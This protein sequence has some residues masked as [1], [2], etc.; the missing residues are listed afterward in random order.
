MTQIVVT[1]ED[2]C[3]ISLIKEAISQLRGVKNTIVRSIKH[4]ETDALVASRL[5]AAHALAGSVSLKNI[6]LS[7]ERTRYLLDK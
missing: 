7:D 5:K 3:N 6:D 4:E 2:N 1:I